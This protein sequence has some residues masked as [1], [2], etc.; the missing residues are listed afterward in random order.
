M[1]VDPDDDVVACRGDAEIRGMRRL[2]GRVLHH[3]G[4]RFTGCQFVGYL[5]GTV[6]AWSD[7]QDHF[8]VA[9]GNPGSTPADGGRQMAFFVQYRYDHR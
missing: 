8:Q 7:H 6:P 3:P 2:A 5:T 1:S 4:S 9:L